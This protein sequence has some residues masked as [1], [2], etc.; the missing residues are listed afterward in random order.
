[1]RYLLKDN[2]KICIYKETLDSYY[3]L[4]G[5]TKY[6]NKLIVIGLYHSWYSLK[7]YVNCHFHM[8]SYFNAYFYDGPFDSGK[9]SFVCLTDKL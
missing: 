5:Y 4:H 8:F 1:M 2:R 7:R 3:I 9:P 6:R